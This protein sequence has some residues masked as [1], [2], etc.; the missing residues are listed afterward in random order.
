MPPD[1]R[2]D[3]LL[4]KKDFSVVQ[5]S[6]DINLSTFSC[7]YPE[8]T[9]FLTDN[10]PKLDEIGIT[11]TYLVKK[12]EKTCAY[13]SIL[14]GSVEINSKLKSLFPEKDFPPYADKAGTL[15]I[16]HLAG[17][18]DFCCEYKHI[19]SF[20]KD[21]LRA[22]IITRLMKFLNITFISLDAD[23]NT[24]ENVEEKYK[25]SGFKTVGTSFELPFMIAPVFE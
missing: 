22:M 11:T 16:H 18:K 19:I 12:G 23:I 8:Y 21:Y 9:T 7:E 4:C 15:H 2:K 5:L 3:I 20:C 1:N 13:F 14:A 17:D 10:A 24:D 6:K 25:K